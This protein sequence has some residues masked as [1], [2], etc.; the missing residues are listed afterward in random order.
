MKTLALFIFLLSITFSFGQLHIT[1][2]KLDVSKTLNDSVLTDINSLEEVFDFDALKKDPSSEIKRLDLEIQNQEEKITVLEQN[3]D[4]SLIAPYNE[5]KSSLDKVNNRIQKLN[6]LLS[7]KD[8]FLDKIGS[9][10]LSEI[11]LDHYNNLESQQLYTNDVEDKKST[12]F[13][14]KLRKSYYIENQILFTENQIYEY[15]E[16][17]ILKRIMSLKLIEVNEKD[18]KKY[19]K[20]QSSQNFKITEEQESNIKKLTGVDSKYFD[21]LAELLR[22]EEEYSSNYDE[23]LLLNNDYNDLKESYIQD[24]SQKQSELNILLDAKSEFEL[25]RNT[26]IKKKKYLNNKRKYPTV[27]CGE[28][29]V[30]KIFLKEEYFRN[31]DKL[32]KARTYSEWKRF[33][34]EEIPCYKFENYDE[35]ESEKILYNYFAIIDNRKITPQ[36]F[37][38]FDLKDWMRSD[39]LQN[40]DYSKKERIECK[41]KQEI[42]DCCDNCSFWTEKQR[43]NNAC[44]KCQ[45]RRCWWTGKFETCYRCDGKGYFYSDVGEDFNVHIISDY[46]VRLRDMGD[47]KNHSD[48]TELDFNEGKLRWTRKKEIY[49]DYGSWKSKYIYHEFRLLIAEDELVN[50]NC[51]NQSLCDGGLEYMDHFLDVT[52]FN[53]GDP[54]QLIEDPVEWEIAIRDNIPAYCYYDN[55]PENTGCIYNVHAWNDNRGLIPSGWRDFRPY[56][57]FAI[58]GS[59]NQH[60][61]LELEIPCIKKNGMPFIKFQEFPNLQLKGIRLTNGSFFTNGQVIGNE[62]FPS[63]LCEDENPLYTKEGVG[64]LNFIYRRESGGGSL[65]TSGYLIPSRIYSEYNYVVTSGYVLLVRDVRE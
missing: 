5:L 54:I 64:H 65:E 61:D 33:C 59:N 2:E 44:Q 40:L 17:L 26:N 3:L 47:Q 53:N 51:Q 46:D 38:L 9:Y 16:G 60:K 27:K 24:F 14:E 4:Q 39:K 22:I 12:A 30:S 18:L 7:D 48:Y 58:N 52:H 20:L 35:K 19:K 49:P 8:G 1:P 62:L 25:L 29:Y 34:E 50:L 63:G 11:D 10:N 37:H 45:N 57:I 21:H 43:I 42:Y 31:G 41:R 36:G 13:I 28:I 32:K 23:Y 6:G 56:D 55:N 15:T